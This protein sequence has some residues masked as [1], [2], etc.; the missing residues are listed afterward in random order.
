MKEPQEVKIEKMVLN[1]D[2]EKVSLSMEQAKKLKNILDELF[3]KEIIKEVVEKHHYHN[4]WYYKP[5]WQT[6]IAPTKW[7][8]NVVYCSDNKS[9]ALS[10]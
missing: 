10:V 5:Y 2:G 4:D 8:D 7:F 3:G 6:N 9:L 1:I